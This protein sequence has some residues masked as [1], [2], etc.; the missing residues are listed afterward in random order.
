MRQPHFF[1]F[2]F[3]PFSCHAAGHSQCRCNGR[4][5]TNGCLNCEFPK[6]LVLHGNN[7]LIS[8]R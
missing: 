8:H 7:V 1:E 6:C 5:H 4:Q 3:F 2:Y